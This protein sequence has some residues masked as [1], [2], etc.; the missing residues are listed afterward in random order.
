MKTSLLVGALGALMLVGAGCTGSVNNG[1]NGVMCTMEAKMCPDGSYV[2]RSGPQCEFA[3]CPPMTTSTNPMPTST[4]PLPTT[5]TSTN[6]GQASKDDLITVTAPLINGMVKSPLMVTGR[7]RGNW[8]F[9]AS[10]PIEVRNS[11]N[12]IIGRG[13]G[14]AQSDW[15][16]TNYVPFTANISFTTPGTATGTL[17]LRKDNPSGEAQFDNELVIPISF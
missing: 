8:Y 9:E 13:I 3:A 14:Q 15:M 7:A 1:N 11:N 12:V 10:F 4:N 17:I 6:S 5:P 16:T 2:G